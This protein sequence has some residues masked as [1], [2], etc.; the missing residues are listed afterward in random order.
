MVLARSQR[1]RRKVGF[2]GFRVS[3]WADEKVLEVGAGD[4]ECIKGC[5]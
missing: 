5:I 2:H 3:V 4:G 1:E